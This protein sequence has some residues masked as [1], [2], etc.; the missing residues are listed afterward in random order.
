MNNEVIEILREWQLEANS[1]YNDGWTQKHYKDKIDE[2]RLWVT[3][4]RSLNKQ[5]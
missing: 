2:V 1:E 3:K 5:G 4:E